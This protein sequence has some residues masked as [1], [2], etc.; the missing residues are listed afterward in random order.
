[1]VEFS[2]GLYLAKLDAFIPVCVFLFH[3]L[4]GNDLASFGVCGLVDSTECAVA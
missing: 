3:L 1:M 2:K 4:Y